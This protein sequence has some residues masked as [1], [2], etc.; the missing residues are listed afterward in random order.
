MT[1]K[2]IVIDGTDGSGKA[3]QTELLKARLA[4]AGL[5]VET[6]TFPQYDKKSAGLVEE[7]LGGKYG[8][9]DEVDPKV[10]SLFYAVDRYDASFMIRQWLA[11]GKTVVA[12]RY[13]TANMGHQGA[14]FA[15]PQ[16]RAAFL[17][18]L[19]DLEYNVLG[20]PRPDLT[21]ILHM[22]ASVAQ[23]L[24]KQRV[25]RDWAGKARDVHEEDL[26]H[27]QAAEATYLEITQRLPHC[28][29]VECAAGD[30]PLSREVVA[31]KVWQI[32]APLVQ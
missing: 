27:L 20:I 32:V 19:D 1:G 5:A 31:D 16:Q 17:S 12:D 8:S 18:W 28:T 11:A 21:V 10:A 24:A 29:L 15:D 7:Y 30:T 4:G 6:V 14:K 23:Q 3:T 25:G 13:T 9:A 22:P 2:F 26:D